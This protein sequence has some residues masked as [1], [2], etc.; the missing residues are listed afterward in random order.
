VMS[1]IDAAG[2]LH[3]LRAHVASDGVSWHRGAAALKVT[4]YNT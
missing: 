3:S 2:C 4:L 1:D